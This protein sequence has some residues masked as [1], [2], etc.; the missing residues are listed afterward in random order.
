MTK[1]EILTFE[2]QNPGVIRLYL[3]GTFYRAYEQSAWALCSFV[4]PMK[5]S[6]SY[7]K[8]AGDYMASVGFPKA[9]LAKWS[10]GRQFF[11]L[12]Y[13]VAELSLQGTETIDDDAFTEWKA[14]QIEASGQKAKI[15]HDPLPAFGQVYQLTLELTK[16]CANLQRTYKYSLG[17]D[18]RRAACEMV[19]DVSVAAKS[20]ACRDI[21]HEARIE[22]QRV[23]MALRMLMDLGQVPVKRYLYFAGL[24]AD[25]SVRL[26]QWER[27]LEGMEEPAGMPLQ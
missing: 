11:E 15:T 27:S 19:L 25:A 21:V 7:V 17:E 23:Q 26:L 9:S 12:P 4:S 20:P 22:L 14:R 13:K 6:C 8:S 3:E 24:T 5:V 18:L 2:R 1:K 10:A 16:L